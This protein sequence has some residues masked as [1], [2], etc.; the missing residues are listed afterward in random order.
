MGRCLLADLP[1][2]IELTAETVL[3]VRAID[4]SFEK[5]R[6]SLPVRRFTR[7]FLLSTVFRDPRGPTIGPHE[8]M[9]LQLMK[10]GWK[11]AALFGDVV[12]FPPSPEE[13]AMVRLSKEGIVG[14]HTF[15]VPGL[16][17]SIFPFAHRYSVFSAKSNSGVGNEIESQLSWKAMFGDS[18]RLHSEI[19]L[20]RALGYCDKDIFTFILHFSRSFP[21]K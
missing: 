9:E 14:H 13:L 11:P 7:N 12:G 18:P 16:Y 15:V 8:G 20:G 1:R 19:I 5:S 17:G 4:E 10:L 2:A 6:Q 3:A 21:R